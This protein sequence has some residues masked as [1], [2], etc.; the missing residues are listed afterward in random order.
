MKNILFPNNSIISIPICFLLFISLN[1]DLKG[2]PPTNFVPEFIL[3][4]FKDPNIAVDTITPYLYVTKINYIRNFGPNVQA[5][6]YVI[7]KNRFSGD[8]KSYYKNDPF[9][10]GQRRSFSNGIDTLNIRINTV[11]LNFLRSKATDELN[12]HDVGTEALGY[13]FRLE[14]GFNIGQTKEQVKDS[15]D[16]KIPR[17]KELFTLMLTNFK[18]NLQLKI[19][20]SGSASSIYTGG[21]SLYLQKLALKRTA[22]GVN[23]LKEK[24]DSINSG[25]ILDVVA[26]VDSVSMKVVLVGLHKNR[27]SVNPLGITSFGGEKDQAI[28]FQSGFDF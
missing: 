7:L 2:Q 6:T 24:Y 25:S 14:F 4:V 17:Y 23:F 5:G 21:D 8:N 10:L 3:H 12:D 22:A 18:S 1:L 20:V 11:V 26:T 15:F 13:R 19:Q 9:S 27:I 16:T 28:R